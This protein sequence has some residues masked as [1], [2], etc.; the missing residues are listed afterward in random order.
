MRKARYINRIEF[1][2]VEESA[3]GYGGNTLTEEFITKSWCNIKT[4]SN[5]SASQRIID[6]GITDVQ[7]TILITLRKRNDIDYNAINQFIKYNGS[8]YVVKS[9]IDVDLMGV[10]VEIIATKE[11]TESVNVIEPI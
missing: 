4:P 2:Q 7:N 8:K 1:W 11:Q 6:F 9:V 10:D 3:D 5:A